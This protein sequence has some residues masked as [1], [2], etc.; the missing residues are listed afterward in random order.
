MEMVA[1]RKITDFCDQAKLSF[2]ARLDL[3]VRICH[4][5]QHA[6]QKGIIHRDI[7]PANILVSI[8]DGVPVPKVIDFG[9]AKATG[10][11]QLTDKTVFTAFEQFIGTPAYM[12][13]EQALLTSQD[14]DTRSD[15]YSLG[16]LLYELLTGKT[17]FDTKELLAVGLDELR[18]TISQKEPKRPSTRLSTLP[19]NELSTTAQRRGLDAPKLIS[20]L[21]GDLDWIVMKALEKDRA[22]R[23]ESANSLAMDIERHLN[24]QPVLAR[25]PSPFYRLQKLVRRRRVAIAAGTPFVVAALLGGLYW[26]FLPGTLNLDVAPTDA[27]IEIDGREYP[28]G[29]TP[30]QIKLA[31]GAHQIKFSKPEFDEEWR[32]ALVPRGGYVNIPHLALKHEEGTLDVQ[33][34]PAGTGIN[35]EGVDYHSAIKERATD[36]GTHELIGCA[37]GFFEKH[38][39]ITIKH[40]ERRSE[41]LSLE[42]GVSWETDSPAIQSFFFVLTN[43]APDQPAVIANNQLN[44][45]AFL[46]SSNGLVLTNIESPYVNSMWFIQLDLG[47]DL[48]RVM[49]SGVEEPE[50]GPSVQVFSS[51]WPVKLL[52]KWAESP[53]KYGEAQALAI[54]TVPRPGSVS[55]VAFAGRDGHV[56]VVNGRTGDLEQ[57]IVLAAHSLILQ[58]A[59][60]SGNLDGRSYLLAL[61]RSHGTNGSNPNELTYQ[62][63][64]IDLATGKTLSRHDIGAADGMMFADFN[65]NGT[66]WIMLW[67]ESQWRLFDP[68]TG[69][70]KS[71]HSLPGRL[72]MVTLAD[73]EG[74]GTDDL[75]FQFANPA[76]PMMAVRPF[77][78]A[79]IWQGPTNVGRSQ[80]QIAGSISP[81]CLQPASKGALLVLSDESL[82]AV[83]ALTGKVLWELRARPNALLLD[84]VNN[85][86]YMTSNDK[87]LFCLNS[88]GSTNW[89]LRM[90]KEVAPRALV[91]AS[92]GGSRCDILLSSQSESI[93]LVHW[94]RLLW[95]AA[96]T[97]PLQA[98]P[99]VVKATNGQSVIVQLGPWGGEAHLAGL[100]GASGRI[101]WANK[102]VIAPNRPPALAP[103]D[104]DGTL[105]IGAIEDEERG[106]ARRLVIRRVADGSLV[107]APR[108]SLTSWMTG[109]TAADFRG[110]GKCDMAVSTWDDKSIILIDGQTGKFLWQHPTEQPNMGGLVAADLDRDGLPDVVATSSDGHVYALRGKDGKPLW[111]TASNQY[112]SVSQPTVADLDGDGKLQ[113]LVTTEQGQLFALNGADG[114]LIW[115]PD[116]VG[117]MKTAGRATV[118]S[119]NRR[120][121]VLAPMGSNGAVAFDWLSRTEIWRSPEGYPTIATPVVADLVHDGRQ[122]V[123]VG[124]TTGEVF[125]LDLADGKPLWRL[126]LAQKG[127]EADPVVADLDNNGV[128]DILIASLDGRLYAINGRVVIPAGGANP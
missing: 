114:S 125:V 123:I 7:K 115:S 69:E 15:I 34:S 26:W 76:L 59:L 113:V 94:P 38:R 53:G 96:A 2:R 67:D 14:I 22:R 52:W 91:P 121:L 16:V 44:R 77:D 10:G 100:D 101:L 17:P 112:P 63:V 66:P 124:T 126:K 62:E 122:Q 8:H 58:P 97:G 118:A 71:G 43:E 25:S 119:R 23:Y 86:I 98:T 1:G 42:K 128:D 79:T 39:V 84:E 88:T 4:A 109:G 51:S 33:S 70:L 36:T 61:L 80:F 21:R 57:D 78:A 30:Q 95:D 9:I 89:I 92:E 60:A 12:S 111:K 24:H 13:P 41:R 75:I 73:A 116:I 81:S 83:Q 3:F 27:R 28:S 55:R 31:A 99:L 72:G 87:R 105:E 5:I 47:A 54:A 11:Q 20:Q 74:K 120:K 56:R 110:I 6:H 35:F 50:V 32:T 40:N 46:S 93:E 107:R 48:G 102:T 49:I 37:E 19:D 108:V 18:R 104:G 65:H 82:V 29:A 90:P 68:L 85:I 106:F 64:S 127:I 117:N 103:F 45:L